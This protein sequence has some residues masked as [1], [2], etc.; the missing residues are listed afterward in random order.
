MPT[1]VWY[2][3]NVKQHQQILRFHVVISQDEDGIFVADVPAIPGCH[4]Q[5]ETYEESVKN[6]EEA[7]GLCLDVAKSDRAYRSQI[8]W[9]DDAAP[10]RLIG[11]IQLPVSVPMIAP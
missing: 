2:N 5:G 6:I 3:K 8:D 7:I 10:S 9:P 1:F 11:M 4:T